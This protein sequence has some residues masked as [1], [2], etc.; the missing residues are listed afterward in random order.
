MDGARPTGRN[1]LQHNSLRDWRLAGLACRTP[2]RDL[3]SWVTGAQQD[4]LFANSGLRDRGRTGF[5]ETTMLK[6][7]AV[8]R[9]GFFLGIFA[10]M[11]VW[12]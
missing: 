7:E 1:G 6:H 12:E 11:A 5:S 10:L 9:L 2:D 8:I 4:G 3:Q